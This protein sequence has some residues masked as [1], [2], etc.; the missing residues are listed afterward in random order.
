MG[1]Y[2][3]LIFIDKISVT[4][5]RIHP[6]P[7]AIMNAAERAEVAKYHRSSF[8]VRNSLD[9]SETVDRPMYIPSY[10][11][12]GMVTNCLDT[13][14][15]GVCF[16]PDSPFDKVMIT[17]HEF[18]E[19]NDPCPYKPNSYFKDLS[20]H[21]E[22]RPIYKPPTVTEVSVNMNNYGNISKEDTHPRCLI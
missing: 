21:P 12:E 14:R 19:T 5:A 9:F 3:A 17:T 20:K 7:S 11:K 4:S 1:Y 22:C 18:H 6:T 2:R 16:D 8:K 10:R 13:F 15:H